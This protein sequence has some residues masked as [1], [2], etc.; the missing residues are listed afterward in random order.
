MLLF[1]V[2]ILK[3]ILIL[4]AQ[5]GF[6]TIGLAIL[7]DPKV[8]SSIILMI[9]YAVYIILRT[10]KWVSPLNQVLFNMLIYMHIYQHIK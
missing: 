4:G 10:K 1:K 5:W 6:Q 3:Y 2:T 9:C 7:L 8:I